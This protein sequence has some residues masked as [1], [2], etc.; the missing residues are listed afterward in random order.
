MQ[1]LRSSEYDD[2]TRP[3]TRRK[4]SG[5]DLKAGIAN[6]KRRNDPTKMLVAKGEGMTKLRAGNRHIGSVEKRNG[7]QDE[8]PEDKIKSHAYVPTHRLIISFDRCGNGHAISA[9][10]SE[11]KQRVRRHHSGLAFQKSG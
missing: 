9:K 11:L 3:E 2:T 6:R 1:I 7:T 8:D 4:H 10:G 5:G